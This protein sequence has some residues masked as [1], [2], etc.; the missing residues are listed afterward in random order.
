MIDIDA[1][2]KDKS[3]IKM[4]LQVHDELIF[5]ADKK[6][7]LEYKDKIEKIMRDCVQFSK[8]KLEVNSSIGEN[9]AKTK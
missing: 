1:F 2:L 7:I 9:W 8:V 6:T 4:L 5:E 3:D